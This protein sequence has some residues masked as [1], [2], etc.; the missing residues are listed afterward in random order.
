ML[1][2]SRDLREKGHAAPTMC[3]VLQAPWGVATPALLRKFLAQVVTRGFSERQAWSLH[4][5]PMQMWEPGGIRLQ[6]GPSGFPTVGHNLGRP[7]GEATMPIL[8]ATAGRLAAASVRAAASWPRTRPT[9]S[10]S[11]LAAIQPSTNSGHGGTVPGQP[12]DARR[13]ETHLYP[14]RL[15]TSPSL[16]RGKLGRPPP[17][18]HQSHFP[19]K[20][21]G[22]DKPATVTFVVGRKLQNRLGEQ[23]CHLLMDGALGTGERGRSRPLEADE[24]WAGMAGAP[25]QG[26]LPPGPRVECAGN[27]GL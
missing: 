3:P 21:P 5:P 15:A 13:I 26:R 2:D 17:T 7:Q 24:D 19:G 16:V 12:P 10:C 22:A 23:S 14:F 27:P 9:A 6:E 25:S 4:A 1:R 20:L 8:Q 18:G 11:G